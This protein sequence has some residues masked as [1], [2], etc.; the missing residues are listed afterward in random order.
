M[1]P[2]LITSRPN[3]GCWPADDAAE[4]AFSS[5]FDLMGGCSLEVVVVG[6]G[7]GVVSSGK[8]V[9]CTTA[10]GDSLIVR[11]IC[12]T[13]GEGTKAVSLLLDSAAAG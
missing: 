1:S 4:A 3:L 7:S 11:L 13:A 2:F 9:D 8:T 5:F 6:A 12:T 10:A